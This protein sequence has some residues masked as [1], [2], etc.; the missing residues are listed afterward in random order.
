MAKGIDIQVTSPGVIEDHHAHFLRLDFLDR[1][2]HFSSGHDDHAVEAHCLRLLAARA[3]LIGAYVDGVMRAG[4]QI[5]PDR[6][7]R[8]A[9]AFVTAESGYQSDE[10]VQS[11]VA[12]AHEEARKCRFVELAVQGVEPPLQA[13]DQIARCA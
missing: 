6:H 13:K 1:C 5:V 7:A 11:L 12:R 3:I 8:R 10:L 2:L 9:E 4:V